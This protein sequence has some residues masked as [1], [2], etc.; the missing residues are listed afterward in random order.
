LAAMGDELAPGA[1]A[2]DAVGGEA[3]VTLEGD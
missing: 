3:V 1:L 2:D